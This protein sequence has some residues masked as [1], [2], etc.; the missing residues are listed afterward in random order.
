VHTSFVPTDTIKV[1]IPKWNAQ[2]KLKVYP[3][4]AYDAVPV[5]KGKQNARAEITCSLPVAERTKT[6]DTLVLTNPFE[7]NV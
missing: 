1:R 3:S 5:C 4:M 7:Y 2:S 6:Y